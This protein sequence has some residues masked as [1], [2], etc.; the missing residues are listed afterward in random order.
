LKSSSPPVDLQMHLGVIPDGN[1]RYAKEEGISKKEAYREA[2]E[3]IKRIG[4]NIS[5]AGDR[6][7]KKKVD[8]ITIYLLSEDNLKREEE[9]L[10]TLFELLE[11]Y[12]EDITGRY[13]DNGFRLNWASTRPDALPEVHRE[14]LRELEERYDSGEKK[15]NLLI[16]YS[17]KSD[18]LQA[19]EEISSNG[20]EFSREKMLEHLQ[21]GSNID[22]VI[23]TGDNPTRECLSDFPIWNASYA[24]Y[25]HI[26]KH[27]PDLEPE[28]VEEAF[29]HFNK[30]R[31]KKGK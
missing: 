17:G 31:R 21:I 5:G 9:D 26:K 7:I 1:R 28:D 15:L 20:E 13:H 2:K 16:S 22:F 25:F 27:F 10:N 19:S 18:I 23:R 12:L 29:E 4:D 30:L 14:K 11:E 24:E 6:D 8:E 3:V